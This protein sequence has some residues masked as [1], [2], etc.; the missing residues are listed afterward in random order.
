MQIAMISAGL[1]RS[2]RPSQS[3]CV[4][5]GI[6]PRFEMWTPDG[7]SEAD[8]VMDLNF[9]RRQLSAGQ[10]AMVAQQYATL[11]NGQRADYVAAGDESPAVQ[12]SLQQAADRVGVDRKMVV[13]AKKV[14]REGS[15]ALVKLVGPWNLSE[16]PPVLRA[17]W[18]PLT[19]PSS[20]EA[21]SRPRRAI[22]RGPSLFVSSSG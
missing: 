14:A 2:V 6:E 19:F 7:K 4:I 11:K 1:L 15:P 5:L 17:K 13:K 9:H 3:A 16:H 20:H 22:R 8:Y 10:R 18:T 12:Q 21:V